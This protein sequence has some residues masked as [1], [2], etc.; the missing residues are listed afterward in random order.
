M[1]DF[2]QNIC[3]NVT[4]LGCGS[5][6]IEDILESI[7]QIELLQTFSLEEVK[8]VCRYL[9]CYAVPRGYLMFEPN[10]VADYLIVILSGSVRVTA[11]LES[12]GLEDVQDFFVGTTLGESTM[13]DGHAWMATCEAIEP[14]DFAVLSR[15]SFNDMLIARPRLANKLLLR[16]LQKVAFRLHCAALPYQYWSQ[17]KNV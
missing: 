12:S 9:Q 16:L 10:D 7:D 6:Y 14:T 5:D 1:L 11:V 17:L 13:M 4:S 15:K 2:N 3:A 8:V